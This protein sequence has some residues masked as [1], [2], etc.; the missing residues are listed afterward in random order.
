[1]LGVTGTLLLF[2]IVVE[3]TTTRVYYKAPRSPARSS[4]A[5]L[6]SPSCSWTDR[7]LHAT[8][9]VG[10]AATASSQAFCCYHCFAPHTG[11]YE[12]HSTSLHD[13]EAM[14]FTPFQP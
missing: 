12:L 8:F 3:T 7:K 4:L 13:N 1:M 11:E 6:Q 2:G 9:V 10:A 14:S 5:P